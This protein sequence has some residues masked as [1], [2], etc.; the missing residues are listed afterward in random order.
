MRKLLWSWDIRMRWAHGFCLCEE[1]YW[2]NYRKMIDAAAFLGVEGIV[3]WG[4]LRDS[5]GG[6]EAAKRVV[7]YGKGRGIR[8][9]PGIGID[10]YGGVYYEGSSYYA[11]DNYIK[12]HRMSQAVRMDGTPDFH[13]W[14]PNDRTPRLKACPSDEKI[15]S[16]YR[17]SIEWL[18]D[19]FNLDGFQIEQGDSGL[20]YCERCRTRSRIICHDAD[21]DA[22]AASIRIPAVIGPVLEKHPDLTIL[23]ETY[24]GLTFDNVQKL[25]ESISRYPEDV[26]LSWQLYNGV[27]TPGRPETFRIDNGIKSPSRFGNAALRTNN[28]LFLGE[29]DD[30]DNIKKALRLSREAGLTMTYLYGEYPIC[31]P[32]TRENY[33]CWAENS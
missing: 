1:S 25:G 8:I 29:V 14:P 10:D 32:T 31:W 5:H 24:C 19:T 4:F 9:Y 6:I 20:C 12:N 22:T 13:L 17:E 33:V 3:I 28:D 30:R 2:E 11:L 21:T 26:V 7:D 18:V 27:S 15:I 23:C 16:Y